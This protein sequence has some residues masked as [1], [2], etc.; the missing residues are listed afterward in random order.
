MLL[1]DYPDRLLWMQKNGITK[2]V[3]PEFDA[4][5]ATEQ[6]N[7]NH[8]YNVGEHTLRVLEFVTNRKRQSDY[9]RNLLP[10]FPVETVLSVRQWEKKERQ[11]LKFAALLHD[12]AKPKVQ[13]TDKNGEHRFPEHAVIG[14]QLAKEI[15]R[16]LKFDNE[17]TDCVNRLVSAHSE[18]ITLAEKSE[19]NLSAMRHMM[20]RLG[21]DL[22]DLLWE[23]QLADVLSQHPAL[24]SVKLSMLAEARRLHLA[25]L[26]REECV[27]LKQ[28][29]VNG[30]DLI[31]L[32][33]QPGKQI[34]EI[35]EVLLEEVLEEPSKNERKA[36]LARAGQILLQ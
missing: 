4:M 21:P 36:L 17:T 10:E 25:V 34:G 18:Y 3:L 5:L 22:M 35:L 28:L 2:I 9:I 19:E 26:E 11:I 13:T 8:Q 14:A 7:R 12:V 6:N 24:L 31:E 32:G 30:K 20:R 27:S 33:V 16:R 29:A 15:M 23:L 1:S